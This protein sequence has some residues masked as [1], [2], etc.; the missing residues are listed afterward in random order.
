MTATKKQKSAPPVFATETEARLYDKLFAEA[1]AG[2]R[3]LFDSLS[4]VEK[5]HV[6]SVIQE[7]VLNGDTQAKSF[8]HLWEIDYIR[9]PITIIKFLEDTD[10]LGTTCRDLHDNW[11]RDLEEIAKPGSLIAEWVSTG[12]IGVGK[13]SVAMALLAYKIYF[14]SCLHDPARYYGLLPGSKIVFGIYSL[15]KKQINEAGYYRLRDYVDRSPF[16]Q[17]NFPRNKKLESNIQFLPHPIHVIPGSTELHSIGLDLYSCAL[18]EANFM[19]GKADKETGEL[20]GQAY[21]LYRSVRARITTRFIRPGG[22]LPGIL[23]LMSSK[24]SQTSFMEDHL[25]KVTGGAYKPGMRGRVSS[26]TYVSD[27][28]WWETKDP[29]KFSRKRFRVEVGDRTSASKILT[30][31]EEKRPGAH[32]VEVPD[33]FRNYF[34][35]DIDQSLRE[36]AGVSTLSVSP[37]IWDRK[38]IHDA[39]ATTGLFHPFTRDTLSLS[40]EGDW[41]LENFYRLKDVCIIRDS[42]WKP[43]LNARSSRYIH[44]DIGLRND[45]AGISM[46][47]FSGFNRVRIER[48]DGTHSMVSRPH[49]VVDFMLRILPPRGG[50]IDLS[51]IRSFIYYLRQ[52]YTIHRVS[53]DG[54]QSVDSV[55]LLRKEKL[56][57]VVTSIDRTDAPYLALRAAYSERRIST[58]AYRPLED[59]VLDLQRDIKTG[60][61]DHPPLASSGGPGRKDVADSLA[62]VVFNIMQDDAAKVLPVVEGTDDVEGTASEKVVVPDQAK[63]ARKDK[64]KVRAQGATLNWDDLEKNL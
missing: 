53:Y 4:P 49:I 51:K 5:R 46:G 29:S 10:Y 64:D 54:F 3:E 47:H 19:R 17:K 41:F 55:Q 61:V 31:T 57:A 6:L 37:L 56:D 25:K 2:E 15:T 23:C 13:T 39:Y 52:F 34:E 28:A 59:E 8:S 21:D 40:T 45:C 24:K 63:A 50:E 32:V 20:L 7:F 62:G 14:L 42:K 33:T 58:Y 16:F 12:A 60:K 11:K 26:D 35:Q 9:K 18:D 27:Y 36:L 1:K 44:I 22:N 30:D 48:P 38:S 43:R